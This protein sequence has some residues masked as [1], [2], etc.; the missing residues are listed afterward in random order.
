MPCLPHPGTCGGTSPDSALHMGCLRDHTGN[1]VTNLEQL[2]LK[3]DAHTISPHSWSLC[4]LSNM[5]SLKIHWGQVSGT[6]EQNASCCFQSLLC[7]TSGQSIWGPGTGSFRYQI[8]PKTI[9]NKRT[10]KWSH[11]LGWWIIWL[12]DTMSIFPKIMI[13][14]RM[15]SCRR[16][17]L[18]LC[19][20]EAG[21][22]A[23]QIYPRLD[24]R[25]TLL[26]LRIICPHF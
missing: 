21:V 24:R 17:Q 25:T 7:S 14:G 13:A 16:Y 23:F 22:P 3:Q 19:D 15:S 20:S 4:C 1:D 12:T 9:S 10:S 8:Q 6:V 18:G 2:K 11:H 5:R 26:R